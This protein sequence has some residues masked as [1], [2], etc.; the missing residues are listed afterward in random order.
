MKNKGMGFLIVTLAFLFSS[1][2]LLSSTVMAGTVTGI[3]ED[4]L[5]NPVPGASVIL[6]QKNGTQ[7]DT[8][9]TGSDGSFSL[10]T[11]SNRRQAYVYAY[12][13]Y[14]RAYLPAWYREKIRFASAAANADTDNATLIPVGPDNATTLS[15]WQLFD[16]PVI[17]GFSAGASSG[18][19][20]YNKNEWTSALTAAIPNFMTTFAGTSDCNATLIA[21]FPNVGSDS[22]IWATQNPTA[23][24]DADWVKLAGVAAQQAIQYDS[25]NKWLYVDFG[26]W[27]LYKLKAKEK[28]IDTENG[29]DNWTE[30]SP[31]NP[32][33]IVAGGGKL[34]VSFGTQGLWMYNPLGDAGDGNWTELN[35][36]DVKAMQYYGGSGFA[37]WNNKLFVDFGSWGAYKLD[38]T[39]ADPMED[40][41]VKIPAY[42]EKLVKYSGALYG[43]FGALGLWGTTDTAFVKAWTLINQ[44]NPD[45]IVAGDSLYVDFGA[46]G[47]WS[48][49]GNLDYLVW[50]Q[51]SAVNP[52]KIYGIADM[53]TGVSFSN[54]NALYADFGAWGL[55]K[56]D[57][58][59]WTWNEIT[60]NNPTIVNVPS[61]V[62]K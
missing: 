11:G 37:A 55:Y 48:A 34:F 62:F 40:G 41:W 61:F 32:K 36:A 21:S 1:G 24:E 35:K 6:Y 4:A 49:K 57:G 52:D 30:I 29:D 27:G 26:D 42:P 16:V 25:T 50:Y 23:G 44:A 47:L 13:S 39:V 12:D 5:G 53:T 22:G 18:T 20:F 9:T 33:F 56:W 51:L 8:K 10:T 59:T 2:L 28:Y 31:L 19:Y 7:L 15:D 43:D 14:N 17:A 58:Y 60:P 46:L 38:P 3:L 45:D 54:G